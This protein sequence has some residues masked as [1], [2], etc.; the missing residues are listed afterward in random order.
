MKFLPT[1][2]Q[3]ELIQRGAKEI[4]PEDELRKKIDRSIK[5]NKP[6]IVKLRFSVFSFNNMF[7]AFI[8]T[9]LA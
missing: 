5:N 4:I 3:L 8:A 6:L 9:S 7:M 1:E 2:K